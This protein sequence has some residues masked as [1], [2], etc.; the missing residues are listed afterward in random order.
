MGRNAVRT[1]RLAGLLVAVAALIAP[2]IAGAAKK[3]KPKTAKPTHFVFSQSNAAS[4]SVY[5]FKRNS[6]TGKITLFETVKTGGK[7]TPQGQQPFGLPIV[8]SADSIVLSPDHKLLFVVNDGSNNV[9]SFRVRPGGITR[10]D[11]KSSHGTLPISLAVHGNLLYVLNGKTGSIF[12]YHY[13][14]TGKLIP[15]AHSKR[16][17]SIP[18]PNGV[19]AD[20]GFNPSGNWLVV[21]MRDLPLHPGGNG[22]KGRIDL[23]QVNS[24]GTVSNAKGHTAATPTPFGFRFTSKG[25]LVDTSA[26][27]VNSVN[28]APPP[29]TDGT[30][31]NG[32]LQSYTI[33]A[34]GKLTPISNA[35]S[36]GRA[37]CW[38]ALSNN[39]R[40]AFV[41]NTLSGTAAHP[42]PGAPI[43]TGKAALARF[44]V[45]PSGKL[46]LLGTVNTGPGTPTDLSLSPD[47][48]YLY[49][50]NPSNGLL[51]FGSHLEVY[52]I[53]SGG[54]LTL[55]QMTPMSL[56]TGLSGAAAT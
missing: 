30:Q 21:T 17:L 42:A 39:N 6:S 27:R 41:T 29:L 19:A 12:G 32:S 18:G 52:K 46:K 44:S 1:M 31:I 20:I 25:I 43:G 14:A 37:A 50:A 38:V 15:I 16:S 36:A 49:M 45:S 51:P 34:N 54:G 35:A 28:N 9:T 3:P 7:G 11:I 10:A 33:G 47:G 23:F 48:K 5:V 26:G 4:N 8:D 55:V 22:Q 53:G 24:N 13:T 56:A 2:S 40:Y